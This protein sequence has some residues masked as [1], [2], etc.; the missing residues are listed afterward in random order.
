M[1]TVR[2]TQHARD[3]LREIHDFIARDSPRAAETLVERVV[4]ATERLAA[5]P[6]SGRVLPEFPTMPYREIIVASYRVLYQ[7]QGDTVWISAV[8]HGRRELT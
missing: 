2:W 8:V 6:T 3:D 1:A 7:S 4:A 5:F